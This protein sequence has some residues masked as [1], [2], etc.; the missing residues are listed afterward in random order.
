VVHS[1]SGLCLAKP[2]GGTSDE[3]V[4]RECDKNDKL[5]QRWIFIEEDWK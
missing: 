4:L 2:Q 1:K 3:I 5:E